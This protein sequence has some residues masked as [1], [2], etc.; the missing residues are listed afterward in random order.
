MTTAAVAWLEFTLCTLVIGFAG[1]KLVRHGD[2][3]ASLTGLS[4]SWIGLVLVA[5]VTSLPEL[6][7]GLSAVTLALSPD[8]ALGDALGSC[9][10]N[11]ML[12]A[13]VQ[14]AAGR[15]TPVSRPSPFHWRAAS[16][17]AALLM[18]VVLSLAWGHRMRDASIGHVGMT[19]VL[20]VIGY[21]WAM[22]RLHRLADIEAVQRATE[23]SGATIGRAIAGYATAAGL[24]VVAGT[25]LPIISV[26]LA[27]AMG[28]S[29]S[30]VGTIFVAVATS[31]P[32]LATTLAALRM[33]LPDLAL[34]NLLGSNLFDL[35][36]VAVDDMAYLPGPLLPAAS[37]GHAVTA[38][39]G[40]AMYAVALAAMRW[41][42]SVVTRAAAPALVAIWLLNLALQWRF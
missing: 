28:W 36:I 30:F 10:F 12:V 9:L 4:R 21:L 15:R 13:W 42:G 16:Y 38:G 1:T 2:D 33:G 22:H 26:Q 31:I 40:L 27:R 20:L 25:L 11:L 19:S 35:L 24:I 3:L 14:V 6:V 32:E 37:P 18:I 23:P 17:G 41:R 7:T 5:T 29:D 8:V 34:A 39:L